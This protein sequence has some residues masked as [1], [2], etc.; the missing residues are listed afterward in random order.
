[1]S[2]ITSAD[3]RN[4]IRKRIIAEHIDYKEIDSIDYF[5]IRLWLECANAEN[6]ATKA[7]Q[8]ASSFYSR[9]GMKRV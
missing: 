8:Q 4:V 7:N 1:M 9:E 6:S 2:M 5:E 3:V